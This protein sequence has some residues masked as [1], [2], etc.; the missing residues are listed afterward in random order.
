MQLGG[1]ASTEMDPIN[2]PLDDALGPWPRPGIDRPVLDV[3]V[4]VDPRP[5]MPDPSAALELGVAY[6]SVGK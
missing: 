3:P 2:G 6:A 4:V 5:P 1:A